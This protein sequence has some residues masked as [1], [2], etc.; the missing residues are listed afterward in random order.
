MQ[1]GNL[2]PK[3]PE[4]YQEDVPFPPGFDT[5]DLGTLEKKKNAIDKDPYAIAIMDEEDPRE[6]PEL[7]LQA[8]QKCGFV[9][10]TIPFSLRSLEVCRAAYKN[11]EDS[12]SYRGSD[13]LSDIPMH[14]RSQLV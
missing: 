4:E 2:P 6:H 14:F 1:V 3:S 11:L 9:L 5:K 8:V 13:I 12:V 10:N 7:C